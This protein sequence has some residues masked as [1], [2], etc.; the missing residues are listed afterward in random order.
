VLPQQVITILLAGLEL[1]FNSLLF[2]E[3]L[4]EVD[5]NAPIAKQL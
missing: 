3:K 5:I 1:S 2:P 4:T